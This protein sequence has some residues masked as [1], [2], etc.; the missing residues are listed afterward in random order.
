MRF[1]VNLRP[2]SVSEAGPLAAQA[3]DVGFDGAW[4]TETTH[5]PFVASTI[6]GGY[7]DRIDIGTA[8]A[9]AFPRSPMVTAYTAWDLQDVTEG[10]FVLG[11]GTQVK[12]HI[13]RRFDCTWDDPGPRIREYVE[14]LR[15]IW[16]AWG[17]DADVDFHGEYYEID[18][19]PP[20]WRPRARS[21]PQVPI[22]VAGVNPFMVKLAGHLCDG[23]HVH[24][25]NSPAYIQQKVL[26]ALEVGLDIGDRARDDVTLAASTFVIPGRSAAERSAQREAVREQI[27]FYASTRT[28]A[29]I[30][31]THGWADVGERLHELSVTGKWDEMPELITDEMVATFAV[32]APWE[33]LRD[34]LESRYSHLDRVAPYSPFDGGVRWQ[35]LV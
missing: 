16:Q 14:V 5:S 10:R 26:P 20:D 7:T 29:P 1:D 12:G 11:L 24:P 30:L 18:L 28:Y 2:S 33:S 31:E 9:V 23:L 6:A 4:V 8:I 27:A 17:D 19:C 3:E 34:A 35:E 15:H 13:E 32:E 25:L 22:Y 21:D